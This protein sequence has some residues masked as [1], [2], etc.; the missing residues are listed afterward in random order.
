MSVLKKKSP[1]GLPRRPYW[2]FDEPKISRKKLLELIFR[3]YGPFKGGLSLYTFLIR[4][5]VFELLAVLNP[6]RLILRNGGMEI[7]ITMHFS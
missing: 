3:F 5:P 6:K 1:I 4:C 2:F 7:R